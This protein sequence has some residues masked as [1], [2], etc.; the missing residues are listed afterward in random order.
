MTLDS[1]VVNALEGAEAYARQG[2]AR[3]MEKL[4]TA[5]QRGAGIAGLDI[6]ADVADIMPITYVKR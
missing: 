5:A 6:S 3:V 2:D 4:L 1:A